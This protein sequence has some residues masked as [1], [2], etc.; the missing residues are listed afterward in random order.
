MSAVNK[1]A[2]VWKNNGRFKLHKGYGWCHPANFYISE[3]GGP[4]SCYERIR[5][6]ANRKQAPETHFNLQEIA[7]LTKINEIVDYTFAGHLKMFKSHAG[8]WLS[9]KHPPMRLLYFSIQAMGFRRPS[10]NYEP[11]CETVWQMAEDVWEEDNHEKLL[12]LL[13]A[14]DSRLNEASPAS[15]SSLSTALEVRAG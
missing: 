9:R 5:K 1:S 2:N 10:Q 6:T 8:R 7:S 11:Q 3:G 13:Q 14:A 4:T 15:L 12:Q